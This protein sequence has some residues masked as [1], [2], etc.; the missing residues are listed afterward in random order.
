MPRVGSPISRSTACRRTGELTGKCNPIAIQ[1][2]TNT[3]GGERVKPSCNWL[4][5]N[6]MASEEVT[7][8]VG[9]DHLKALISGGVLI[10]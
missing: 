8:G 4:I 6:A 1:V 2:E 10:G 7:R 5:G 3:C 9:A